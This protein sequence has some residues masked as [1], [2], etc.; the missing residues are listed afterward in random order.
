MKSMSPTRHLLLAAVIG[1][2]AILAAISALAQDSG[3]VVFPTTSA[4]SQGLFTVPSPGGLVYFNSGSFYDNQGTPTLVTCW[5]SN[6]IAIQFSP[7]ATE[8]AFSIVNFAPGNVITVETPSGPLTYTLPTSGTQAVDVLAPNMTGINIQSSSSYLGNFGIFGMTVTQPRPNLGYV[9]FD[10]SSNTPP[11]SDTTKILMSKAIWD[12]GYPSSEQLAPD[13]VGNPQVRITGTL[14]DGF[15]GQPKAGT[16]YLK[17]I[18]P[19][20]T[21]PYRGVDATPGD[22]D[23]GFP[24]LI[25]DTRGLTTPVQADAQG[26]FRATLSINSRVAGDNYQIAGSADPS[27]DCSGLPCPKSATFTLWKRVYVE[28]EHMFRQGS[29]LNDVAAAGGNEIPVADPSPFQGLS[30]GTTLELIHADSGIGEGFYFDFVA[31]KSITQKSSG[32]WTIQ[33]DPGPASAISRDY[34]AAPSLSPTPVSDIRRDAVGVVGAGTYELNGAYLTP[35]FSTMFVD[36]AFERQTFTEVPYVPELASSQQSYFGSRWLQG[37]LSRSAYERITDPN[38]LHRIAASQAP[39]VYDSPAAQGGAELGA[40]WIAGGTNSS[41]IFTQRIQD[42]TTAGPAVD[43]NGFS[44]GAEYYGL[45]AFVLS[46]E[47]AAH[48]TVHFWVHQGGA[49]V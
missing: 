11:T 21:A 9:T 36:F 17:V 32:L 27:F 25:G 40:T 30:V 45:N 15:T 12:I 23:G 1:L 26:R 29:F 38:V 43:R 20:D 39:L 47:T 16:V 6:F 46:G 34:G 14:Y 48:E 24:Q 4:C 19:P 28:E 49:D 10:V 8:V 18:D 44:V 13:N 35:L 7:A 31:F 42:L 33:T 5:V 41:F 2:A 3:P 37:G 22:N